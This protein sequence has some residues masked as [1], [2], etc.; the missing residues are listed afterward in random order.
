MVPERYLNDRTYLKG[1]R[2]KLLCRLNCLPVMNRVGREVKPKWQKHDRVCFACGS[3]AVEDVHH[4]IM[5][6]PC[7]EAKRVGMM[8]QIRLIL[9][10][11]TS[12]LSALAFE[13][14]DRQAQCEVILGKRIGTQLRRIGLTL[15]SRGT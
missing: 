7:Y 12:S 2:L 6:C 1:T 9:S 13:G 3:G 10:R 5:A 4:F 8:A 11:S 15:W 14:M